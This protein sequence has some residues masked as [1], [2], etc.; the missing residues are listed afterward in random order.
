MAFADSLASGLRR[1]KGF[2][3]VGWNGTPDNMAPKPLDVDATFEELRKLRRPASLAT[4]G[5]FRP[6][7]DPT[8]SW[9]MGGCGLTG[10][11]VPEWQGEA[12]LPLLQIR[13]DELP[14]VPEQIRHAALIVLFRAPSAPLSS[15]PHGE[16]WLIRE[17]KTLEGLQPLPAVGAPF[18]SFPIEW[19]WADDDSPGWDD[20]WS[21]VDLT[22]INRDND[23]SMRFYHEFERYSFTKVGGYPYEIQHGA[24][25]EDFVFQVG[26]ED[27]AH[28]MWGDSGVAYFH[29]TPDGTWHFDC[30]FH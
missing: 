4:V 17:Y 1:L 30:Q 7:E 14:F 23:A 21:L 9:F 20:A 2:F 22:S 10:E 3:D 11:A 26:T 18:K 13:I 25:V 24:G 5:G 29:R 27:K 19:T 8:C 28:W 16:G 12:M 15:T 6:P